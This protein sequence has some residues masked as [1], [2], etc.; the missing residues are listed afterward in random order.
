MMP[1]TPSENGP[2]QR[3][4]PRSL[5]VR[6]QDIRLPPD[7]GPRFI[8]TLGDEDEVLAP[9]SSDGVIH[10]SPPLGGGHSYELPHEGSRSRDGRRSQD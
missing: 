2:P 1:A 9:H 5:I 4:P 7:E 10:G 6:G 8:L 3:I